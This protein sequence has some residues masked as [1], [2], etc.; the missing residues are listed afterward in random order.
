MMAERVTWF[1]RARYFLRKFVAHGR[2]R[3]CLQYLF[4]KVQSLFIQPTILPYFITFFPHK[5]SSYAYVIPKASPRREGD[6]SDLSTPP[7]S[8]WL[9]YG[10]TIDEW[11]ASGKQHVDKMRSILADSGCTLPPGSRVLEL[12]CAG[13]R[14]LRWMRDV[15]E[16]GEVWGTDISGDHIMWCKQALSPPFH[17]LIST[18]TPH[19]PFADNYFDVIYAGSVFSH[20]DDMADA[21]FLELRRIMRPDGRLYV[22]IHDNYTIEVL[23]ARRARSLKNAAVP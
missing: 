20:I 18:T 3:I 13:G 12:G 11:L 8:L 10:L 14:M 9:G 21:W 6:A 2:V 22:T 4:A 23:N 15:A 1:G 16:Q 19:L 5:R 7:E 17:F